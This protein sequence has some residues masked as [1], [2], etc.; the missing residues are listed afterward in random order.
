VCPEHFA[1]AVDR[2]QHDP[3]SQL[4]LTRRL[5]GLRRS[6]AALRAGSLRFIDAPTDLLVFERCSPGNRLLCAFN[7]G[8][9]ERSWRPDMDCEWRIIESVGGAEEWSFPPLSGLIARCPP[10]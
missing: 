7:L 5:I 10:P 1:L 3:S 4:A 6:S 9:G 2:Q 8:L